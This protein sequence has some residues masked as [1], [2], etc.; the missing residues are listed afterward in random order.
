LEQCR[1]DIDAYKKLGNFAH[2][3]AAEFTKQAEYLRR[4]PL[5]ELTRRTKEMEDCMEVDQANEKSYAGASI[6]LEAAQVDR[7]MN[8]LLRHH[9]PDL[10]YQ[11]VAEDAQG[12]R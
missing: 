7:Y 11:F 2:P 10:W 1:L 6:L 3:S 9:H 4:F 5:S 8:F 12:K